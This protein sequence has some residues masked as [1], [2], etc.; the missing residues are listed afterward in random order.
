MREA[1]GFSP[2]VAPQDLRDLAAVT[3]AFWH[4]AVPLQAALALSVAGC[5][6]V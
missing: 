5:S 1:L 2:M 4:Q 3:L 6:V